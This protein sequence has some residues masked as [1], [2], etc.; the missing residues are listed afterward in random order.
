MWQVLFSNIIVQGRVI[1]SLRVAS[2]M[3]LAIMYPSP[4]MILKFFTNVVW[5]VGTLMFKYR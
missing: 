1:H 4:G 2:F 3:T 5:P